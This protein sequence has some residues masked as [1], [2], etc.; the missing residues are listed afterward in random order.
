[1]CLCIH[2]V[3]Q[4]TKNHPFL[5]HAGS[6]CHSCILLPIYNYGQPSARLFGA[7]ADLDIGKRLLW[8]CWHFRCIYAKEQFGVPDLIKPLIKGTLSRQIIEKIECSKKG[9]TTA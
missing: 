5:V 2:W 1:V 6:V 7:L 4:N 9:N 3:L 8:L